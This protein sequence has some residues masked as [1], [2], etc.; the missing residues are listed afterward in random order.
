MSFPLYWL[1]SE[2]QA[3]AAPPASAPPTVSPEVLK[4]LADLVKASGGVQ[5]SRKLVGT[6]ANPSTLMI[7]GKGLLHRNW[8]ADFRSTAEAFIRRICDARGGT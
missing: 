6:G 2:L 1:S 5:K 4:A 7:A 3:Q 8:P